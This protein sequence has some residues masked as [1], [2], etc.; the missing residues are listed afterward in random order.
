MQLLSAEEKDSGRHNIP[1]RGRI[2]ELPGSVMPGKWE[3]LILNDDISS[4]DNNPTLDCNGSLHSNIRLSLRHVSSM[5]SSSSL[6][7]YYRNNNETTAAPTSG[8][9]VSLISPADTRIDSF[10]KQGIFTE[11][12]LDFCI[13]DECNMASDST[14]FLGCLSLVLFDGFSS[15]SE[16]IADAK[17]CTDAILSKCTLSDDNKP[18]DRHTLLSIVDRG[19]T[20]N[21]TETMGILFPCKIEFDNEYSLLIA[22][23]DMDRIVAID[24]TQ[25]FLFSRTELL[26]IQLQLIFVF[27][28]VY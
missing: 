25:L 28:L 10:I 13:E 5:P 21:E 4:D 2:L 23:D 3:A 14:L 7:K 26:Y 11:D 19:K 6:E 27:V 12:E 17:D 18:G 20:T 9:H 1:H 24:G 22:H 8:I 15:V 16:L